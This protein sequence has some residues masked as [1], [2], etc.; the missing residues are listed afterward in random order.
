MSAISTKSVYPLSF[1]KGVK[2]TCELC[3]KPA[4]RCCEGCKVTYYW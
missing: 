1:P 3:Q 2:L 4:Y